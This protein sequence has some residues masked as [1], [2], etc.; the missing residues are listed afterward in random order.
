M[1]RIKRDVDAVCEESE[2]QMGEN[3][4]TKSKRRKG[5]EN[6]KATDGMQHKS[7]T[8][9]KKKKKEREREREREREKEREGA[10]DC[11]AK[12]TK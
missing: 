9:R 2:K 1:V 6:S 7:Q 3:A 12:E 11:A 8:L 4:L 10:R 5:S